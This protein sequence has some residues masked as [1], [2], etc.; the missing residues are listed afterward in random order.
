M[1]VEE[2]NMIILAILLLV[3]VV[4]HHVG[5]PLLLKLIA[6]SIVTLLLMSRETNLWSLLMILMPWR[7]PT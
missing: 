1:N 7:K 6:R 4:Y 3:L 2:A 5:Y